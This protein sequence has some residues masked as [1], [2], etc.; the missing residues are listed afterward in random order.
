M[1]R[2]ILLLTCLLTIVCSIQVYGL[3]ISTTYVGGAGESW[4]SIRRGVV[5]QAVSEWE[6]MILDDQAVSI[7]FDFV[8]A[9]AT[10][11]GQWAGQYSAMQ[12]TDMYPWSSELNHTVH[13]NAHY[14]DEGLSHS[15]FFDPTPDTD[16]DVPFMDFDA[17][18]VIRHEI[19][20]AMGFT[21]AFYFDNVF[22]PDAID[23][24]GTHIVGNMF[25][26]GDLDIQLASDVNISHVYNGGYTLNDLMTPSI[27][28]SQRREISRIDMAMLELAY[29]YFIHTPMLGDYNDDG[30]V[31]QA[32]YTVWADSYGETGAWLDADG[33]NDEVIDQADYTIWADHYGE[34]AS[35]P[36]A[37][38]EPSMLVL[39]GLGVV[40]MV[41]RRSRQSA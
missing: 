13:V 31:D 29:G 7:T 1:R 17:L 22:A 14:M 36:A 35:S 16:G 32:D 15:L 30:Y 9:G 28:N 41:R 6:A 8:D 33:N 34:S 23:K 10:Y 26:P 12:G 18:S 40:A 4:T 37:V 11:L 5:E 20:H 24:W 25:D 27:T 21:A 19:G 39:F 38:P 2:S 3:N